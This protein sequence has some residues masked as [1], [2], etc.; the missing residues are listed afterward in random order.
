M[1]KANELPQ[2][3]AFLVDDVIGLVAVSND[4]ALSGFI[5]L[6]KQ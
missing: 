2:N 4:N 3:P 1:I 5:K 6:K